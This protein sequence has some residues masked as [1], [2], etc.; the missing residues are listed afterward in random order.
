[1]SATSVDVLVAAI[2]P[3]DHVLLYRDVEAR[4][5]D[6]ERRQFDVR[7]HYVIEGGFVNG[8]E[9]FLTLSKS[10][11][12]PRILQPEPA[13]PPQVEGVA[14]LCH[15]VNGCPLPKHAAGRAGFIATNETAAGCEPATVGNGPADQAPI[16][17]YR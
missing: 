4:I 11:T 1:M 13:T 2:V 9:G 7:L 14:A 8:L 5:V 16:G 17:A 15:G 10:W 12:L 6:V 3:G